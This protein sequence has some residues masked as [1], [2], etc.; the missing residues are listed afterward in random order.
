MPKGYHHMTRDL[1]C[2][3]YALKTIGLS[4]R[5]IGFELGVSASTISR[6]INRNS[7]GRG[8]RYSQADRKARERRSMASRSPKK[9]T[10]SLKEAIDLKIKEDWSPEQ[11]AGR[12][13]LEGN[14]ISHE[15]IYRHI[16]KNKKEDG[17]LYCHLRHHGKRYNKRSSSK[18]GRGCIPNRVDISERPAIV[19]EKSRIGDWEGDTI[20]GSHHKGAILTY[21]DRHSKFTLLKKL[22]QKTAANVNVATVERMSGLPHLALTITYDNGK[23]FSAHEKIADSLATKCYFARP[24]HSWERGLN[25]HTNG[26]IRQYLPKSS[27]FEQVTDE[28]VQWIEERLNNRPRKVL[29]YRT[30]FEIFYAKNTTQG[31]ALRC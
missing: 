16:W 26:L 29:E 12:F 30:P 4:I 27:D 17:T 13:K 11:I 8:Y 6:E 24:Y 15:T 25:E 1:R 22:V 14:P 31:V 23:E 7:G 28:Q 10:D 2:Q 21:V 9:M 18:A 5:K 19:E 20:I 3:I